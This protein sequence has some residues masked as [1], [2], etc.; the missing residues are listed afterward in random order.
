MEFNIDAVNFW[1]LRKKVNS[2]LK[3]NWDAH[4]RA[5]VERGRHESP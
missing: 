2:A 3:P 5:K 1:E 4:T